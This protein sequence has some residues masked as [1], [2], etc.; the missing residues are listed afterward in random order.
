V[1]KR[2]RTIILLPVLFTM[3]FL[4]TLN[5]NGVT[6][7]FAYAPDKFTYVSYPHYSMMPLGYGNWGPMITFVSS[8]AATVLSYV[9]VFSGKEKFFAWIRNIAIISIVGSAI[10]LMLS[11]T[12]NTVGFAIFA[13]TAVAAAFAHEAYMK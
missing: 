7:R 9:L 1:D 13:F 2:R 12:M 11:G 3:V 10:S 4:L 8:L 6:M 5:P